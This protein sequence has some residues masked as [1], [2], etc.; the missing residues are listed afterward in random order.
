MDCTFAV[1]PALGPGFKEKIYQ[2]ATCLELD[3]RGLKFECEKAIEVRFKE[4]RIPG[5]KID[6]LVEQFVLV[7]MK[8]VPK[9]RPLHTAQVVSY[10]KTLDLQIGLLINF[11]VTVLKDGFKRVVR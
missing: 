9:L 2:R 4:W 10:L 6:L 11:N 5:Q 3:A 8:V 1:H 7:E